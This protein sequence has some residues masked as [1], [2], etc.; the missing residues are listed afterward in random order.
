MHRKSR[1]LLLI[2]AAL[3]LLTAAFADTAKAQEAGT[4]EELEAALANGGNVTLTADV[5]GSTQLYAAPG[6]TELDLNNFT[7]TYSGAEALFDIEESLR[8]T[9]ENPDGCG[10]I[11]TNGVKLAEMGKDEYGDDIQRLGIHRGAFDTDPTDYLMLIPTIDQQPED[12][13]ELKADGLWYVRENAKQYEAGIEPSIIIL[14]ERGEQDVVSAVMADYTG[15]ILSKDQ[16]TIISADIE[17]YG[18]DKGGES[19]EGTVQG[20]EGDT[21]A[22]VDSVCG[23]DINEAERTITVTPGLSGLAVL[24]VKMKLISGDDESQATEYEVPADVAVESNEGYALSF[25]EDTVW[26]VPNQSAV[27]TV[28]LT[29]ANGE[30]VD[31]SEYKLLLESDAQGDEDT[32]IKINGNQITVTQTDDWEED[33]VIYAMESG[34]EASGAE[35]RSAAVSQDSSEPLKLYKAATLRIRP[36]SERPATASGGSGG[37]C[38][39]FGGT[40][41]LFAAGALFLALRLKKK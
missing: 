30:V 9:D 32:V 6:D 31:P 41:A 16:Y 17:P 11:L 27:V 3:L 28:T 13:M 12:I 14:K 2:A 35:T 25:S 4:W 5:E 38:N 18:E 20:D 33:V 22:G 8:I 19:G 23:L 24:N 7:I 40:A 34:S 10:K 36:E 1:A 26:T 29:D 39:A 37:G 21:T 15:N